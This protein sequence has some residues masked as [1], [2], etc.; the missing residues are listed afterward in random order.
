MA[1]LHQRAA[2]TENHQGF[3]H[4]FCQNNGLQTSRGIEKNR[5]KTP[6]ASTLILRV[7][8]VI[9]LS[10][11]SVNKFPTPSRD[12]FHQVLFSTHSPHGDKPCL[13]LKTAVQGGVLC[14]ELNTYCTDLTDAIHRDV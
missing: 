12:N 3:L 13:W 2:G 4:R 8:D 5:I 9:C 7:V 10:S 14:D 1:K 11:S 6:V